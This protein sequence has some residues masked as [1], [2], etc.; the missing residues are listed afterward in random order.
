MNRWRRFSRDTSTGGAESGL[1]SNSSPLS[2]MRH[3]SFVC[4]LREHRVESFANVNLDAMALRLE[5]FQQCWERT[6]LIDARQVPNTWYAVLQRTQY[7]V[8]PMGFT[9]AGHIVSNRKN[10]ID[11]C[12]VHFLN[13]A[14]PENNA[15]DEFDD[16]HFEWSIKAVGI[17]K[18]SINSTKINILSSSSPFRKN[19][20]NQYNQ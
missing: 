11:D 16:I 18:V 2:R 19:S 7:R 4:V 13:I 12:R 5:H 15:E 17:A 14:I 3:G 20:V 6:F 1:S 8:V 9:R 10:H